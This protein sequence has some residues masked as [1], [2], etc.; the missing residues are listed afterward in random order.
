MTHWTVPLAPTTYVWALAL[1]NEAHLP[2]ED[3]VAAIVLARLSGRVAPH[4]QVRV[5]RLL[6]DGIFITP[7]N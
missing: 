4:L 1:R 3:R 6:P 5:L 2:F 7:D